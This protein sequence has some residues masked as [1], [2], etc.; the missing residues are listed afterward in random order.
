MRPLDSDLKPVL[1]EELEKLYIE[2]INL[3]YWIAEKQKRVAI[4]FEGRD[5]AGKGGAVFAFSQFLNPR[6][7]RIV[8]LPKPS[9]LEKGQWYFQRYIKELPNPGQ[10]CFFDRSWYN[11]AVV[12]PVMGFCTT[13]EYQL[14]MK[15]VN[16]FEEMLV[17]DGIILF[18]FWFSINAEEQVR[19]LDD[20]KTNPLKRWK[21][22]T[23]DRMAQEKW[24]E[25]T[26]FKRMMFQHTHTDK[27]PWVI[28]NGNDKGQARIE[29]MRYVLSSIEYEG[30][31]SQNISL[32]PD[33]QIVRIFG[34]DPVEMN[35]SSSPS[36]SSS[37]S[38]PEKG[39]E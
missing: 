1:S 17:D 29:A 33:P 11:R 6:G 13:D 34:R 23:V 36:P 15:Q 30:R 37:Q 7:M 18:K 10:V 25:Y 20:R 32:T 26:A 8:A 12:E 38:V 22:S 21:L 16:L 39:R 9:D 19:R 5:T 3:Q 28:I 27:S 2:L 4:L 24:E 35:A 14:F 31:G